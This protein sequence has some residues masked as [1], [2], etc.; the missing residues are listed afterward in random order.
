[1]GIL[2]GR[3]D[4]KVLRPREVR[5][6]F[7]AGVVAV[8]KEGPVASPIAQSSA[9]SSA[10]RLKLSMLAAMYAAV[11]LFGIAAMPRCVW[12]RTSTW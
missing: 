4:D 9:S 2:L 6:V 11:L 1:M 8:A 12:K 10:A 5:V 3:R 7:G